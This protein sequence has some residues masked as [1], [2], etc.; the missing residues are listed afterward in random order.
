MLSFTEIQEDREE[1]IAKLLAIIE[2]HSE[3]FETILISIRNMMGKKNFFEESSKTEKITIVMKDVLLSAQ[4]DVASLQKNLQLNLPINSKKA[5]KKAQHEVTNH[6]ST[7]EIARL[8]KFF[9]INTINKNTSCEV[10]EA[11]LFSIAAII[12]KIDNGYETYLSEL[13]GIWQKEKNDFISNILNDIAES[14]LIISDFKKLL[15]ETILKNFYPPIAKLSKCST[16]TDLIKVISVK[17]FLKQISESIKQLL[18]KDNTLSLAY[19][20]N[21]T[22]I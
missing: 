9:A 18:A 2:I 13:S 14:Y 10:D 3:D 17:V 22:E 11:L 21:Q 1:M 4:K 7:P 5:I 8:T 20:N 19:V 16:V 6:V 12:Q 15:L